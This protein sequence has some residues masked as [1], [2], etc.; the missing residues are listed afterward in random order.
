MKIL[1]TDGDYGHCVAAARD[2]RAS[3]H[4]VHVLGRSSAPAFFSSAVHKAHVLRSEDLRATQIVD[5]CRENNLEGV[6]PVGIESVLAVDSVRSEL[7]GFA[8]FALPP[9]SSLALSKDKFVLQKL[10]TDLTIPVPLSV[11]VSSL[12]D[13]HRQL[14]EATL[15]FVLKSVS[16]LCPWRPLYVRSEDENMQL[17]KSN[18]VNPYFLFGA[19]QIQQMIEG[20]GEGFFA[21]YQD[22]QCVRMMTHE[23]LMEYPPSGGSSWLATSTRKEDIRLMGIA[24]L[25]ALEWHGPAMVEFKRSK[26]SGTAYLMELNPKLWG[27]L[28]LSIA[29]GMRVPSD[30]GRLIAGEQL[31]P[32]FSYTS[33]ILFWWPFNSP[34]ALR[35]GFKALGHGWPMTNLRWFDFAPHLLELIIM[36]LRFVSQLW[37]FKDLGRWLGWVRRLGIVTATQRFSGEVLGIPTRKASEV[38]NF[39][40]VGAK[41]KLVRRAYLRLVEGRSILSLI[42]SDLQDSGRESRDH[43]YFSLPEYVEI[44]PPTLIRLAKTID[45]LRAQGKK[46]LFIVARE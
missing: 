26:D 15:P 39:L 5:V 22:G 12:D 3:G 1:L 38:S 36:L 29:S 23:R 28:A 35:G 32:D 14:A 27:S 2:L 17:L 44:D 7:V 18:S 46:Y 20:L 8:N 19:I 33:G 6:I 16:H 4:Q 10:A 9:Q 37:L 13:L 45:D 40:W 41:P 24:L 42:E 11:L 25:D 43:L 30:I 34:D 31:V 21:L